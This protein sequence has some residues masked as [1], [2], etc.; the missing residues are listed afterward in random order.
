M[1]N[2]NSPYG[3]FLIEWVQKGMKV[4]FRAIPVMI[5]GRA[6]GKITNKDTVFLP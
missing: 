1:T 3:K 6:M 2:D 5:P 4:V